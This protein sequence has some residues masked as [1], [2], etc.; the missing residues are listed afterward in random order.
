MQPGEGPAE[1]AIP[2]GAKVLEGTIRIECWV[3]LTSYLCVNLA[4][5]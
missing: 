3:S 1:P 2:Q 4:V 5:T